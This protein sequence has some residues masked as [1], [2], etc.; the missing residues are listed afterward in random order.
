MGITPTAWTINTC[1][2]T[3]NLGNSLKLKVSTT[4]KTWLKE[5]R[6]EPQARRK[7]VQIKYH[8]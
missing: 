4:Q 6:D 7:Y 1:P 3:D 2:H 5:Y 8:N